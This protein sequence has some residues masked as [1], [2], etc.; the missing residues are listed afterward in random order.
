MI[1]IPVCPDNTH[2]NIVNYAFS[3]LH[4]SYN[5]CMKPT[6]HSLTASGCKRDA[7]EHLNY[8]DFTALISQNVAMSSATNKQRL[9][10]KW[11]VENEVSWY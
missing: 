4:I 10:Y 7:W 5:K 8:F 3:I 11:R 6:W 2:S 1:F 9:K